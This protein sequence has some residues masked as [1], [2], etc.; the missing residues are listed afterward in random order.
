MVAKGRYGVRSDRVEPAAGPTV[1]AMLQKR[2]KNYCM[3]IGRAGLFSLAA[4][5]FALTRL[6]TIRQWRRD[7]VS[8]S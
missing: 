5:F 1:S 7:S 8:A 4:N 6:A 2:K 3:G